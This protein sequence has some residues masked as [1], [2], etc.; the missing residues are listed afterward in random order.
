MRY[1]ALIAILLLSVPAMA[2]EVK[3]P[4]T[5]TVNG[6]AE[7]KVVPDEA[8]M[9]VNLSAT[10][11]KLSL[12]KSAHDAKLKKLMGI[13]KDTGIPEKHVRTQHSNVQP[14]YSYK[15][16]PQGRSQRSFDGYRVQTSLDITVAD[17]DKLGD[18]M[19]TVMNAN[20]EQRTN[21][22]W[23]SLVN[24]YYTLSE[25]EKVRDDMLAEAMANAKEKAERMA[26]AAGTSIGRVYAVTEGGVPQF[27][28]PMPM[29]AMAARAEGVAMDKSMALPAGEQEVNASVTVSYELKD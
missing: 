27:H 1:L 8:H 19:E 14:I 5:I 10:E 17:T 2:Q 22:E 24:V 12:A 21:E 29:M 18:L 3:I 4:R 25:P 23:N 15:H 13:V 9:T 7:R 11:K 16:D 26:S 20:F 28:P 6:L